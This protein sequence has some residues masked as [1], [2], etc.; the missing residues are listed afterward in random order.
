MN[1]RT[2]SITR[3]E[4]NTIAVSIMT[5]LTLPSVLAAALFVGGC[6][7]TPKG[8]PVPHAERWNGHWYKHVADAVTSLEAKKR[9]ENMEGH[10]VIIERK[11]ENN[12]VFDLAN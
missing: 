2:Q 1:I 5:K 11:Y 12:F 6:A 4:P 7:S 9:S 3:L 8:P 10:L